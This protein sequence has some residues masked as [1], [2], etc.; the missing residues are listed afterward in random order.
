MSSTVLVRGQ[1]DRRR[2]SWPLNGLKFP[3]P[4]RRPPA[5]RPKALKEAGMEV[6]GWDDELEF[7]T[8][9]SSQWDSL[10]HVTTAGATYNGL[11]PT[12]AGLEVQSTAENPLPTIEHW[13]AR[14]AL[15]GRGVLIDWKR[16]HEE[17]TGQPFHPLDGY[18]ITPDD[19]EKAA[20]HQGV[21]FRPGDILI[22]RTG[23]TEVLEAPTPETF[24]K[25]AAATLS[26]LHGSVET[27]R[28]IWNRR[29]SAVAGDAHGFEAL[30]PLRPDG[31][32]G[33]VSELGEIF[34]LFFFPSSPP[35]SSSSSSSSW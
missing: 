24:A 23:Y 22:I 6:E 33:S 7:N 2:H 14:G 3:L 27:A 31:T 35:P 32:T 9:F 4:G 20:R 15:V 8:Q 17:T 25:F 29:F 13:H 19:V 28:W 21:E 34:F 5:H 11:V 1:A 16:Y 18:R 10:C 26:G 12:Q 30:P